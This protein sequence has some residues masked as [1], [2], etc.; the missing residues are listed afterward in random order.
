MFPVHVNCL[1]SYY[2]SYNCWSLLLF[3][4]IEIIGV[5]VGEMGYSK[6][7]C[8]SRGE[9]KFRPDLCGQL[10]KIIMSEKQKTFNVN[11]ICTRVDVFL[12]VDSLLDNNQFPFQNCIYP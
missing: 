3:I 8:Q 6:V 10:V 12:V 2:L 1:L 9:F 5:N 11:G 4:V 7:D